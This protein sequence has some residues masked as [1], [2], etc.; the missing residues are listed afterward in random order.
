[1]EEN[2]SLKTW[3]PKTINFEKMVTKVIEDLIA[4]TTL[5]KKDLDVFI[6]SLEKLIKEIM[7]KVIENITN[8]CKCEKIDTEDESFKAFISQFSTADSFNRCKSIIREKLKQSKKSNT[9]SSPET[10][11]FDEDSSDSD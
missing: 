10:M 7:S 8:F 4:T 6:D 1:M 5:S 3:V 9:C 2:K 11:S